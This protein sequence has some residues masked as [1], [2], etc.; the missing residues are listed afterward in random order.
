LSCLLAT[1]A[2]D[3]GLDAGADR[4]GGAAESLD[5]LNDGHGLVVSDLTEND[6]LAIEPRGDNGGDEELGAVAK[7][8]KM[9]ILL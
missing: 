8:G 1:A 3:G 6:V 4:A 7:K 9:L 2:D 5:G